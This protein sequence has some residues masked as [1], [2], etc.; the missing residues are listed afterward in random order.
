MK[1]QPGTKWNRTPTAEQEA[2]EFHDYVQNLLKQSE[3]DPE[4]LR[5]LMQR[6]GI[7]DDNGELAEKYRD[8]EQF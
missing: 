7:I 6:A 8:P 3:T 5:Q 1:Y 4:I 2:K